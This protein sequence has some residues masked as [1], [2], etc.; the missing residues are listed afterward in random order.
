MT[1]AKIEGRYLRYKASVT[2]LPPKVRSFSYSHYNFLNYLRILQVIPE[3]VHYITTFAKLASM[4]STRE[5]RKCMC[6]YA[7]CELFT[8]WN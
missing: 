5:Q 8:D 2:L 4:L 3:H 1:S 6:P 7:L